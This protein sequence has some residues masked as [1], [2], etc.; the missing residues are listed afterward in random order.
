MM[1]RIDLESLQP[2]IAELQGVDGDRDLDTALEHVARAGASAFAITGCG[3]MFLDDRNV[4][5]YAASSDEPGRVLETAQEELG[6]GPC[7]DALLLNE[8]IALQDV[9]ADNRWPGLAER[10]APLGVRAVL[11]VP[12]RV[13]GGAVGSRNVYQDEPHKWDESETQALLALNAVVESLLASAVPAPADEPEP[14]HAP[15]PDAVEYTAPT[16]WSPADNSDVV[17]NT[18]PA[19]DW[20]RHPATSLVATGLGFVLVLAAAFALPWMRVGAGIFHVD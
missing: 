8:P 5:R 16:R 15:A 7:I 18:S 1:G 11:G 13:G 4:L 20:W 12:I 6:H 2:V 14:A 9:C 17:I 19:M 3:I 10:V